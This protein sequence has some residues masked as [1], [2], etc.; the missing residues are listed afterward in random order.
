MEESGIV[1]GVLKTYPTEEIKISADHFWRQLFTFGL[2]YFPDPYIMEVFDDVLPP[3]AKTQYV[4]SRQ[5][6]RALHE[7]VFTL[8]QAW[9]VGISILVTVGFGGF[10][11]YWSKELVGLTAILIASVIVNAAVTGI[12]SNVDHRYQSRVIWLVPLL[13]TLVTLDVS[14]KRLASLTSEDCGQPEQ[15]GNKRRPRNRASN[16]QASIN[17]C[18]SLSLAFEGQRATVLQLPAE[19]KTAGEAEVQ[20]RAA[21]VG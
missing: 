16:A 19:P 5:A 4:Q 10:I 3:A 9:V 12:L 2:N 11:V 6:T 1:L 18:Q 15:P 13:A 17:R 8:V 21:Y 20:E 14:Q 7:H